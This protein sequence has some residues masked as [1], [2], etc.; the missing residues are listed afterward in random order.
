VS[1]LSQLDHSKFCILAY[2]VVSKETNNILITK[3]VQMAIS[4]G[5][6]Y[7]N[8]SLSGEGYFYT[9]YSAI[10][11]AVNKGITVVVAAGNNGLDLTEDCKI[12]PACYKINSP[13]FI[14]VGAFDVPESNRAGFLKLESGRNQGIPSMSGS[15]QAVPNHLVRIIT[16]REPISWTKDFRQW[17]R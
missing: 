4:D 8:I 17:K 7:I 10:Y 5:T 14:V 1:I 15:S 2:K 12:Y 3:A 13:R 16:N 11:K 9:E 6:K